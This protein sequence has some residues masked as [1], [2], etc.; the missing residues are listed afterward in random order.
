M[1]SLQGK[2]DV[3]IIVD[4]KLTSGVFT[5]IKAPCLMSFFPLFYAVVGQEEHQPPLFGLG[6]T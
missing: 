5:G 2:F 1:Q 6:Q 4:L 3:H